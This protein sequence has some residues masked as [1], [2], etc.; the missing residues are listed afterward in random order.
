MFFY[1]YHYQDI[2]PTALNGFF[3]CFIYQGVAPTALNGIVL[4]LLTISDTRGALLQRYGHYELY[5]LYEHYEH[6]TNF[7]G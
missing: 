1:C 5:K 7:V 2:A 3:H 6:L 4:L